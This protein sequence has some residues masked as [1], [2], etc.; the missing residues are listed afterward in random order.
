M[1]VTDRITL[2]R[3][4]RNQILLEYTDLSRTY[5]SVTKQ[6]YCFYVPYLRKKESDLK[7]SMLREYRN[8][9]AIQLPKM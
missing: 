3:Q 7:N 1:S 6:E 5:D 9:K 2:I 4:M 8:V